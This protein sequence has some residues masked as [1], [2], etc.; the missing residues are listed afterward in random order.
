MHGASVLS[1]PPAPSLAFRRARNH[2][3]HAGLRWSRWLA[4][5]KFLE[6]LRCCFPQAAWQLPAA[7]MLQIDANRAQLRETY[8]V[9]PSW[10]F[11]TQL[12]KSNSAQPSPAKLQVIQQA[13]AVLSDAPQAEPRP[14]PQP[15][16]SRFSM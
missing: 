4:Q 13:I 15:V 8:R 12:R 1:F 9:V 10:N 11:N 3:E 2:K 14:F 5:L 7:Q 6:W 16:S